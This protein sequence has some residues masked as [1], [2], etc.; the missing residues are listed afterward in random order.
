MMIVGILV[1]ILC[2]LLFAAIGVV[3]TKVDRIIKHFDI[4]DEYW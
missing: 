4:R 2:V 3:N 1:S